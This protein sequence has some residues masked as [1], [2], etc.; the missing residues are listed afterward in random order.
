MLARAMQ[1]SRAST[2]TSLQ[3]AAA[4]WLAAPAA[5]L[6]ATPAQQSAGRWL[7]WTRLLRLVGWPAGAAAAAAAGPGGPKG[8]PSCLPPNSSLRQAPRGRAAHTLWRRPQSEPHAQ[9]P[10]LRRSPLL[11][12]PT[13]RPAERALDSRVQHSPRRPDCPMRRRRARLQRGAALRRP[14]AESGPPRAPAR[15]GRPTTTARPVRPGASVERWS[16]GQARPWRHAAAPPACSMLPGKARQAGGPQR[17]RRLPAAPPRRARRSSCATPGGEPRCRAPRPLPWSAW[18][19]SAA[20]RPVPSWSLPRG[21]RGT[22]RR[23][24]QGSAL[25]S[26]RQLGP[27]LSQGPRQ[28]RGRHAQGRRASSATRGAPAPARAPADCRLAAGETDPAPAPACARSHR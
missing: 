26:R 20:T 13:V 14:A 22:A 23:W 16:A 9:Q 1:G 6:Q 3:C 10:L 28:S 2:A 21:A 12:S 4:R 25:P 27:P 7:A 19:R 11:Q 18:S 24:P 15:R 5:P 17:S 8:A